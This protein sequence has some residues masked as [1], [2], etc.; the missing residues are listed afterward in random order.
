MGGQRRSGGMRPA[1][2][3]KGMVP[4][5]NGYARATFHRQNLDVKKR[6]LVA[7]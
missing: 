1:A 7:I 4:D 3:R 2:R 5:E 6:L